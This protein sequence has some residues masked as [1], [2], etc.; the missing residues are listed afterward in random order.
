MSNSTFKKGSVAAVARTLLRIV[1]CA[2]HTPAASDAADIVG[3][4]LCRIQGPLVGPFLWP[5]AGSASAD[6]TNAE[7]IE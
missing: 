1:F 3:S 5:P 6:P 4:I 2:L 7:R